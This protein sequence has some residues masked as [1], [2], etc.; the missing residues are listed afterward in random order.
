MESLGISKSQTIGTMRTFQYQFHFCGAS[1]K[2]FIHV[3]S[4]ELSFHKCVNRRLIM[5]CRK[6]L[7]IAIIYISHL[8]KICYGSTTLNSKTIYKYRWSLSKS[9]LQ[10]KKRIRIWGQWREQE[11]RLVNWSIWHNMQASRPTGVQIVLTLS[12]TYSFNN[13][14]LYYNTAK[15]F[16]G[17]VLVPTRDYL[18]LW[19]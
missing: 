8:R 9:L 16:M 5:R 18:K 7:Q 17:F 2:R 13:N 1:P 3:L 11:I 14:R 10:I 6:Q 15:I 4:F 19:A 12:I